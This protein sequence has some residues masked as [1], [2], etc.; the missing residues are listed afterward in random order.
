MNNP[1]L[2]LPVDPDTADR[3]KAHAVIL[4]VLTEHG[5]T[6]TGGCRT[7]Y[8]PAEWAARGEA[9]GH[10]SLLIVVYDGG[11][12]RHCF[13]P[14]AGYEAHDAMTEA[15]AAEGFYAE[16]CTHWYSAIYKEK[17]A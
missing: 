7:F 14:Y 16:P 3:A 1:D 15:L 13:D 10:K 8:T 9:Y 17:R 12:A 5:L 2:E 6:Y 4:R 11:D